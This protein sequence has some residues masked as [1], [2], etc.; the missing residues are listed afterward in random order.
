[1]QPANTYY[2]YTGESM[3]TC[4]VLV[5]MPAHNKRKPGERRKFM[6]HEMQNLLH[7]FRLTCALAERFPDAATTN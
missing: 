5:C 3:Y 7:I 1:M 6:T 2:S 4:M